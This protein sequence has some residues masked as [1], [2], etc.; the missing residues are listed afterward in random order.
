MRIEV[1]GVRLFVDIEGAGLVA[2][3]PVMREK[4]VLIVLHGGPGL[5]HAIYKPAFSQLTDVAQVVYLDHRGNG[6]S[7]DGDPA[8]WTLDQWGDDIDAL[9]GVLGIARPI[10]YGASFGGMVAQA[11]ATRHPEKVGALILAHTAAKVDF[12]TMFATFARLGGPVA[13]AAARAYWTGPT[14]E[15]RLAY[16]DACVP[17]YSLKPVDPDFWRRT[18]VKDPVALH[19]NSADRELGQMDFRAALGRV[20]CPALVLSGRQDPVMPWQF[21]DTIAAS[22]TAADVRAHCFE[23]AAHIPDLDVPEAFFALLRDFIKGVSR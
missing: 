10:V 18:I 22:L 13:E 7:E 12:E 14:P 8:L 11:Y 9:C 3:G 23:D 1:N 17:L 5:D 4:P 15:R 16:R 2:E 21:A 19:F 20:T 6:R